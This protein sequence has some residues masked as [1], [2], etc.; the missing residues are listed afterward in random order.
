TNDFG[1]PGVAE[2]AFPLKSMDEALRLRSHIMRQFEQ[3]D[4]VRA[5]AESSLIE[6]GALNFVVVGGGPTGVEIAGAL[7]EWFHMVLRKDYPQLDVSRAH[8]ILIEAL[9]HLL[10]P[11]D[12]PLRENTRRTLAERGVEVLLGEAVSEVRPDAVVLKSGRVIPTHTV[13]WGA[14]VK[15]NP[16]AAAMGLELT[17]GGRVVVEPDLTVPGRPDVYVIGD[18]AASKDAQGN[19]HPQLAQVALQGAVHVA[20]QIERHVR[21]RWLTESP[22]SDAPRATPG[23]PFVYRDPGTMA[24]IGRHAA[25]AQF[26]IGWRF[27]G[28][29]AWL[30]WLFLHLVFLIGFRNRLNVLINWVWNYFTYDRSSRLIV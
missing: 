30:M 17:R 7:V 11:F 10:A 21:Q 27:T 25:V 8:V 1:I 9:D 6:A 22:A 24:T 2:H 5:N 16:L 13:I 23:E 20:R 28:F 29:V 14:G 3:A 18:L 12:E 26:P 15:G 19:L 4:A